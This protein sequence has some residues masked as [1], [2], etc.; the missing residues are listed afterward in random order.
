MCLETLFQ[1]GDMTVFA[2][3]GE[4]TTLRLHAVRSERLSTFSVI[5]SHIS[6]VRA[7][8][9]IE[10]VDG[11]RTFTDEG[12]TAWVV[13]AGGRAQLKVWKV[14]TFCVAGKMCSHSFSSQIF[15]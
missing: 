2:T 12:K 8:C 13:S 11:K 14:T 4:D 5:R 9:C 7:M 10:D 3:G 1:E 6:N 15:F